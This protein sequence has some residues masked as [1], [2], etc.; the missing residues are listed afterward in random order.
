MTEPAASAELPVQRE[1]IELAAPVTEQLEAAAGELFADPAR[2]GEGLRSAWEA[3][4]DRDVAREAFSAAYS[5]YV[6][7]ANALS[8]DAPDQYA[9]L[10][11]HVFYGTEYREARDVNTPLELGLA[12]LRE[13]ESLRPEKWE[14]LKVAE[15][16]EVLREVERRLAAAAGRPPA[17]V[18][19]ERLAPGLRGYQRGGEIHISRNLVKDARELAQVIN[20]TAHEGRH[21]YQHYA[22]QHPG[23]HPNPAQV[24]V[25]TH[26]LTNYLSAGLYGYRAYF[27]Q[28]VEIDA[29]AFGESVSAGL[30]GGTS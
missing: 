21:V 9:L 12:A 28:P 27:N 30:Y 14:Q 16:I 1:D 29:R 8:R 24:A 25:W 20:T 15:R 3:L 23:F 18:V 10:R 7:D 22:S 4:S 19:V 6:T 26:N 11:D 13:L 17:K 5:A 2:F